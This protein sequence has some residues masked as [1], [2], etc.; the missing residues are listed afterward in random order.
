MVSGRALRAVAVAVAAAVVASCS[1]ATPPSTKQRSK[2]FFSEAEYGPA[3]PRVIAAGLPVPKG[4]GRKMLGEPYRV[5]GKTYIPR[6]NPDYSA[7]G[8]ASW[9]GEAFHGRL[10]ANGE[11]YD[12]HGLTAAHPTMPLPSYAR[13]TNLANGRSIIVRVNDRGPFHRNRVIDVSKAVA[14]ILDFRARGTAKVKVDYVGPAQM[15]GLDH[16]RLMASYR[17]RG[18]GGGDAFGGNVMLAAAAPAP[19]LRPAIETYQPV[20]PA[21]AEPMLLPSANDPLAPLIMRTGFASGYAAQ[22]ERTGAQIAAD[23]FA[24]SAF[25]PDDDLQTALDRAAARKAHELGLGAPMGAAAVPEGRAVVQLGTFAD[26]ANAI[27]VAE[28]FARY[29]H[30]ESVETVVKGRQFS[31]VRVI[32]GPSVGAEAVITAASRAGLPGAFL[33]H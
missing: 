20:Q 7:T 4:G 19:R 8:L 10:T 2:E 14:D 26:P 27:R 23:A 30:A 17:E 16:E 28:A 25:A 24:R 18:S 9:Y 12:V 11:I 5:A 33:T 22:P 21:Y 31:V 13:V 29:G 15:D 32:L 1:S 6:D 3:S